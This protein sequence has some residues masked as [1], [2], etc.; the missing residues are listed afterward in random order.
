MKVELLNIINMIYIEIIMISK[1]D[2]FSIH[3]VKGIAL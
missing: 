2:K 1:L 3:F